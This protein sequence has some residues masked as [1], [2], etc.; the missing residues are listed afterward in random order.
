RLV[1]GLDYTVFDG[2][3]VRV[4]GTLPHPAAR[5]GWNHMQ[6]PP[7]GDEEPGHLEQL[8]VY[9]IPLGHEGWLMVGD[10]I[11]KVQRVG[12]LIMTT[13]GWA[14]LVMLTLAVG[15]GMA[16]SAAFLGRIDSI[17]RTAEAIIGG[18]IRRRMPLRGIDDDIDRLSTTL[19]RM[20]DRI[21]GLMETLHQVSSDIAHDLR[22]PL[23]RMR[24][25]LDEARNTAMS[26]DDY[27]VAVDRAL[28]E[29]DAI[30]ETFAAI[31]R[32]AQ[33]ESGSRRA[34]F[35]SVDLTLLT[36][37]LTQTYGPVAEDAGC[38]LTAQTVPTKDFHG[39]RELLTQMLVNLIEN[40]ICHAGPGT[41]ISVSIGQNAKGPVLRVA[42]NGPG[43]PEGERQA[44]LRR[45]Y[46]LE[47]SRTTPGSGLGLSLVA[48]IVDLHGAELDL[49][50]NA[51]GL[52]V[53]VQFQS[54]G[55]SNQM[56]RYR[57]TGMTE[58]GTLR[59]AT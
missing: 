19:N 52:A 30:M 37:S 51:P 1:G 40:A 43:I 47:R 23:S 9:A 26:T 39:D 27:A 29:A 4:Y 12:R 33:I 24:H 59:L 44:V 50:D 14:L 28:S 36:H 7:D 5:P 46:R 21:S 20:L 57:G 58:P 56:S 10:D 16:L 53:I 11:G 31:L 54:G 42:D 38:L 2:R 13:F 34:N 6:G 32:I 41:N 3:G 18:D 48:A 55:D 17:T 45:F 35:Q 15:G 25:I 22:T 8:I 49:Q